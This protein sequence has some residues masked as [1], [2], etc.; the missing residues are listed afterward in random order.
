MDCCSI[1]RHLE[2]I[3]FLFASNGCSKGEDFF[4]PTSIR[5]MNYMRTFL[6]FLSRHPTVHDANALRKIHE[7]SIIPFL[8]FLYQNRKHLENL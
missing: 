5:L 7:I 4:S 6:E 2:E 1:R 8:S 3:S